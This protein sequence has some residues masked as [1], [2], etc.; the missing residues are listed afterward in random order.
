MATKKKSK[1]KTKVLSGAK[2]TKKYHSGLASDLTVEADKIPRI[3]S[4]IVALNYQLNGGLPF[5]KI[6]ELFGEESTG[7][8]LLATDFAYATQ[9]LGGEVLWADAENTFSGAWAAQNGLDLTKIHLLTQENAIE[10]ISD[11]AADQIMECRSRLTHNEPILFVIDSTAALETLDNIDT[12]QVDKRAE[13][14]NR[15]KKIYEF[16]RLRTTFFNKMGVSVILINQ[17]RK[18]VGAGMFEDP[19]TTPGGA[20]AKFYAS[21]RLSIRR[22]KS[23]KIVI[24][25]K[26]RK[27]GQNVFISTKKDKTGPPRDTTATQVYFVAS[28]DYG[29]VGFN[30]YMGLTDILLETKVLEKAKG[31]SRYYYKDKMV[32]NGEDSLI[33]KLS[34]DEEFRKKM[35]RKSGINTIS[36]TRQLLES[37]TENLYPII[38]NGSSDE[39]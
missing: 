7:K 2:I 1:A 8:S 5:G 36:R 25:S 35:I 3:P 18:K 11:W 27:V 28:E 21:Q 20:A 39:E 17:L 4:R 38:S 9:A 6:M 30:K 10:V 34:T 14:G 31:S 19:D 32:A 29:P 15:A 26:E 24:R 33:N 16:F 23:V 13:M 22:G 37:L 12:S